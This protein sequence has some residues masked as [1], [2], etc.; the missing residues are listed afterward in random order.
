MAHRTRHRER[1]RPPAV[2]APGRCR[3]RRGFVTRTA[4]PVGCGSS[5][6]TSPAV[7][8]A[9]FGIWAG[10]GSCDEDLAHAGATHYLEHLL[11]KARPGATALDI[12]PRWTR[13]AAS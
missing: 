13:S 3:R 5:P 4:C 9:A 11:F 2:T 10:V 1:R 6:S 7:R 8:S 12:S